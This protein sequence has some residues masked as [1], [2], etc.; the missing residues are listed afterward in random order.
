M[1]QYCSMNS[2]SNRTFHEC[3]DGISLD[4]PLPT[5]CFRFQETDSQLALIPVLTL[6]I[7]YV[8]IQR[9]AKEQGEFR[10][11]S[12]DAR[13]RDDVGIYTDML[14][15]NFS[16]C[17]HARVSICKRKIKTNSCLR[18]WQMFFT[19][20]MISQENCHLVS[21]VKIV[22]CHLVVVSFV[23]SFFTNLKKKKLSILRSISEEHVQLRISRNSRSSN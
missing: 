3:A 9:D 22:I 16:T 21:F 19:K 12:T 2:F 14:C 4:F 7:G 15:R 1:N 18:F 20:S 10:F 23:I 6:C 5:V 13:K 11:P 8:S 17:S